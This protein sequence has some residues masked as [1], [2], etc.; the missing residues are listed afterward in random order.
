M[1]SEF[2]HSSWVE[3]DVNY[4]APLRPSKL[5]DFIGQSSVLS[6]MKICIEAAKKRKEALGHL[7]FFG[8]P[9]LGKTTLAQ[10]VAKEMEGNLTT[11][12]GPA[13]EKAGDLAGLLTNLKTG[14]VLFIDEIHRLPKSI[15]EYLYSAMEDY[16]L[17]LIIDTGPNARS[18]P[19]KL[20]PFTLV[21]AT[22]K[23]GLLSSPLRSR[24]SISLRL[25]FYEP[26]DL[27]RIIERSALLLK[28]KL[29][30]SGALEI[31]QRAR[32]TPR[33]AN[34]LLR[35]VRDFAE[36]HNVKIID[37][38]LVKKALD[39]LAID[40]KGLDEMDIKY[41]T[42]IISHHKGGPVGIQTIAAALGEEIA[43]LEE[44]SEP[45]LIMQGFL[46]RT[47][48]GRETTDLAYS[49]LRIKK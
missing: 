2:I 36:T 39:L 26:K 28:I 12:S 17:D 27:Q 16:T 48:R 37:L 32:G 38:A 29:E 11:T 14:D 4:E 41:L 44:V 1:C 49:H 3:S 7:L 25:D 34:N 35:W 46:R 5:N 9:G 13:L 15:E 24:F 6:R 21:A 10:I 20:N 40:E 30:S 22:T 47:P 45:Y 23:A 18:V 31:A 19:L 33:I 42:T 8:P 43:T